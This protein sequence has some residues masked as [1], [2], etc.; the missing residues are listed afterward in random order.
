MKVRRL[1][2]PARPMVYRHSPNR[3]T[4]ARTSLL[5]ARSRDRANSPCASGP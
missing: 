5:A 2:G 1:A 3:T 4:S